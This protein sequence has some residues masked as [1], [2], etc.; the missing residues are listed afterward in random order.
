MKSIN[1]MIIYG[2]SVLRG[3]T[4]DSA[5]GRYRPYP[6]HNL[7]NIRDGL[8][9]E[10]INRARMGATVERGHEIL[11][12]TLDEITPDTLVIFELGGNDSDYDWAPIAENPNGIFLPHTPEKRFMETYGDMIRRV[13][14][15]G[16]EVALCSLVPIVPERY[17]SWIS[18]GRNGENILKW[19]GDDTMLYR[20]QEHYNRMVEQ[21]ARVNGCRLIDLREEFLLSHDYMNLLSEDGIHPSIA[22]HMR[23]QSMLYDAAAES[24]GRQNIA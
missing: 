15:I 23:I 18:R 12:S 20:F 22:G 1:K 6:A 13:Q 9:I 19:L 2:D 11:M 7:D 14:A 10:V 5:A 16:A 3:I 21:L 8:G 17:L 24:V 4:Y